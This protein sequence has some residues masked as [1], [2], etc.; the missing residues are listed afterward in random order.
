[1]T[2]IDQSLKMREV[3]GTLSAKA[4]LSAEMGNYKDAAMYGDKA[5]LLQKRLNTS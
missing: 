1:M 4:R 5:W 3:F 2:W